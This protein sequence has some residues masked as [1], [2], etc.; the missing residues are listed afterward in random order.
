[1]AKSPLSR[2]A[3]GWGF[4]AGKGIYVT[5]PTKQAARKER[6]RRGLG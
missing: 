3:K 5:R 4:W 6:K 2:W 1:M